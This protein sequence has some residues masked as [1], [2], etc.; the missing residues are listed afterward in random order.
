MSSMNFPNLSLPTSTPN[1]MSNPMGRNYMADPNANLSFAKT[2]GAASSGGGGGRAAPISLE[3]Q[4]QTLTQ[5]CAEYS[6]ANPGGAQDV[7]C[8]QRLNQLIQSRN[9]ATPSQTP[10]YYPDSKTQDEPESSSSGQKKAQARAGAPVDPG[11]DEIERLTLIL[12]ATS[13]PY[14]RAQLTGRIHDIL[15]AKRKNQ[16]KEESE[17][18]RA[19]FLE[20]KER[21]E[22]A[23]QKNL[24]DRKAQADASRKRI[25]ANATKNAEADSSNRGAYATALAEGRI[26]PEEYARLMGDTLGEGSNVT[27]APPPPPNPVDVVN[28]KEFLDLARSVAPPKP[29]TGPQPPLGTSVSQQNAG[30]AQR[31]ESMMRQG[32]ITPE[33]YRKGMSDLD[34]HRTPAVLS[35]PL[36]S[37]APAAAPKN[38]L[39]PA[40]PE[41]PGRQFAKAPD[42]LSV[43]PN[44]PMFGNPNNREYGTD[45]RTHP[46]QAYVD[47]VA[48]YA[49]GFGS[50]FGVLGDDF[51]AGTGHA[52]LKGMLERGEITPEQY[53]AR[54]NQGFRV[55]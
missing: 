51:N 50:L 39:A 16:E 4:I 22:A 13:D 3:Q 45:F 26:T 47:T 7:N 24:A 48:D 52:K 14:L 55:Y 34:E 31:L 46:M 41:P 35:S 9:A 5:E 8:Q 15:Y 12:N 10:D 21:G 38:P 23:R 32:L 49:G 25:E 30:G 18:R 28:S 44:T 43:Q 6:K 33:Q 36:T 29:M 1:P 27:T 54:I 53:R 40:A 11:T 42:D 19:A 37:P 20:R 17:A 2:S